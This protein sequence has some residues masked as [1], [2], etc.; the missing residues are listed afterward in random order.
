[1][2]ALNAFL[3]FKFFYPS[4]DAVSIKAAPSAEDAIKIRSA[5]NISSALTSTVS[6]TTTSLQLIYVNLFLRITFVIVP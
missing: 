4:N 2:S 5:G 1:M 3:G 6:P